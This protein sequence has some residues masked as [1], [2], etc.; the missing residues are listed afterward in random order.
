MMTRAGTAALV[1]ALAA[2]T[3]DVAG[4]NLELTIVSPAANSYLSDQVTLEA[5]I[6]PAAR[7]AEV[8]DV[9]FYVDGVQ[10][11][12]SEDVQRPQ[13]SWDAGAV[14]KARLVRVVAS[15][16]SGERLATSTRTRPVDYT[17]AVDVR[18]VQVSVIVQ[19]RRGAFVSGLT[20]DQFRLRENDVPQTISSLASEDAPLEL[21]LAV[22]VSGSMGA[23]I[24][25]LKGAVR[26]FFSQ[27]QPTDRVTLVAFN[28]EMFVL[29]KRETDAAARQRAVDALASWGN[30]SLYDV[31]VRSLDLLS[32]QPGRRAL[33]VFS[34]GEDSSSQT[35]RAAVDRAL[36]ES[37]ATLFTVALGRGREVQ[38]LK[39]TLEA[40]SEPSGGQLIVADGADDLRRAF[41]EV[42]KD[43]KHQYLLGFQSTNTALDGTWR[44][45]TV[46][47]PG[48]RYRVRAR[49]GYMAAKP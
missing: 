21:V 37:D 23:S 11:C 49:Q 9:T 25:D 19:D 1:L 7:R 5:R 10:V 34:D 43:L 14:V 41:D 30:T 8:K 20:K 2:S 3:I 38:T 35:T 45:L 27:L 24:E 13:C 33:V 36:K 42:L 16:R 15:L 18:A 44:R 4:Q 12:R 17:E 39:D 28:E 29:A 47:V 46:E 26:Q 40:L 6:A 31:I 48:G 32:K 22:D